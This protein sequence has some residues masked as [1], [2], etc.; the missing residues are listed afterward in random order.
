MSSANES[1]VFELVGRVVAEWNEVE[2][3]WYLIY[4]C[5]L[6]EAPRDKIDVIFRQFLTGRAQ[7]QFIMALADVTFEAESQKRYRTAL[8]KLFARTN[9]LS[10]ERNALIHGSYQQVIE[11][12]GI[13]TIRIAPGGDMSRRNKLGGKPLEAQLLTLLPKISAVVADLDRLRIILGRRFLPPGKR[14]P[15]SPKSLVEALKK[16][17]LEMPR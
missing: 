8:G 11:D 1:R 15:P 14:V 10:T 2:S 17:G 3:L 5:L 4:T 16:L 9:D 6:H 13:H 7:R 12:G